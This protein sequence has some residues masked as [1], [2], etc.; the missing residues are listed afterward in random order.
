MRV[1]RSRRGAS[2]LHLVLV[3]ACRVWGLKGLK[4]LG[5]QDLGSFSTYVVDVLMLVQAE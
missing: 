4:G 5:F 1:V 2:L 3:H